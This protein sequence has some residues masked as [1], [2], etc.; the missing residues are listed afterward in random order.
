MK[1]IKLMDLLK[2]YYGKPVS[3]QE[4]FDGLAYLAK[5]YFDITDQILQIVNSL[6]ITKGN[7][8]KNSKGQ[9]IIG[10][11]KF[12]MQRNLRGKT[13]SQIIEQF[14]NMQ[15]ILKQ[16]GKYKLYITTQYYTENPKYHG[17][18]NRFFRGFYRY[19]ERDVYEQWQQ[20]ERKA[21]IWHYLNY[22]IETIDKFTVEPNIF[23]L[24]A[25]IQYYQEEDRYYNFIKVNGN[26]FDPQQK[27]GTFYQH[28]FSKN[29]IDYDLK[30]VISRLQYT[31]QQK[32]ENYLECWDKVY[33]AFEKIDRLDL[34]DWLL[35]YWESYIK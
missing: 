2:E 9:R 1:T 20:A 26:L 25:S 16:R 32:E 12:I 35:D 8:I 6:Q 13:K 19:L 31:L 11:D 5:K 4:W 10:L 18:L 27:I 15:Q 17:G 14:E 34:I 22:I 30:H 28:R 23:V 21:D 24:N 29:T 7:V 33:N 3:V